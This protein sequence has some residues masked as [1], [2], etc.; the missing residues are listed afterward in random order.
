[1][2]P[3]LDAI[4]VSDFVYGVVTLRILEEI[5]DISRKHDV[6][7]FGDLQCSSQVGNISRFQNFHLISPTEREA[8]IALSNH[9]D[10]VE[11][12][13]NLLMGKTK[14]TNIS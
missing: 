13:A 5:L 4:L 14:C 9:D 7:V 10:G 8:R 2:G 11:Y 12:V 3:H 6:L 1:M